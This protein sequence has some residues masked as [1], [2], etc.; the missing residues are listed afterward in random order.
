MFFF[1]SHVHFE[2]KEGVEGYDAILARSFDAG[3][4]RIMAIG[5]SHGLNSSALKVSAEYAE[6]FTN[7]SKKANVWVF[8]KK[9]YNKLL[10][11]LIIIV[12]N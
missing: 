6:N 11:I 5:G 2:K 9:N 8:L 10:G 1:D 7:L 12:A 4:K 3:T